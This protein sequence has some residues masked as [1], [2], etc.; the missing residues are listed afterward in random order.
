VDD[1]IKKVI[2]PYLTLIPCFPGAGRAVAMAL[3]SLEWEEV[4]GMVADDDTVLVCTARLY[5]RQA[6]LGGRASRRRQDCHAR[7]IHDLAWNIRPRTW[8]IYRR[9]SN[10]HT[11]RRIIHA[12]R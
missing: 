10:I 4:T 2:P 5:T 7:L 6:L 1:F 9:A 8:N 11:G 3:K 12:G